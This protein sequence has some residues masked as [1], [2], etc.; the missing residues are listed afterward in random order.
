[1]MIQISLLA[2][3]ETIMFGVSLSLWLTIG[4]FSSVSDEVAV[5]DE[6]QMMKD[7]QRGWAWTRALLGVQAEEIHVCGEHCSADLLRGILQT[8]GEDFEVILL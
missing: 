3:Y 5:I 4:L 6:I 1:M 8:T 2:G 7:D